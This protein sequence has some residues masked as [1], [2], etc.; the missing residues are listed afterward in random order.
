MDSEAHNK[1]HSYLTPQAKVALGALAQPRQC[2]SWVATW[3]AKWLGR[4]QQ[5]KRQVETSRSKVQ[6]PVQRF[7]LHRG[8]RYR[9]SALPSLMT[10]PDHIKYV[11][12][13]WNEPK[14][15]CRKSSRIGKT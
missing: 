12:F 6:E 9:A 4:F 3:C 15:E 13:L 14:C 1:G 2:V 10:R 11:M 8:L 5:K 7:A